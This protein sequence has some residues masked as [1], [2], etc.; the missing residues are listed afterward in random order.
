M[1]WRKWWTKYHMAEK[2]VITADAHPSTE[3]LSNANAGCCLWWWCVRLN[4]N[5]NHSNM[6]SG[7]KIE[8]TR[9]HIPQID[10]DREESQLRR[11]CSAL[12]VFMVYNKTHSFPILSLL[13]LHK[14]LVPFLVGLSFY[15][16]TSSSC[17]C[18]YPPRL[19]SVVFPSLNSRR[20][21]LL[22]WQSC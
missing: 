19:K 7:C 5:N 15:K 9:S 12:K 10:W 4:N 8:L 20:Q 16:V 13:S 17:S 11:G 3:N 2:K 18:L 21:D 22:F 14:N 6:Y 1:A